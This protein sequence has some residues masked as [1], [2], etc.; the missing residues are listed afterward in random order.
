VLDNGVVYETQISVTPVAGGAD[1]SV[2]LTDGLNNVTPFA[3]QFVAGLVPYDGRVFLGARTGGAF[4]EHDVDNVAM[5]FDPLG[6]AGPTNIL[7]SDFEGL[8][9][10]LT[11]AG[12]TP[13]TEAELASPPGPELRQ[14]GVLPSEG[15]MRLT[16]DSA[17]QGNHIAFDR[18][19]P[20]AGGKVIA[21][22]DF[23]ILDADG[24]QGNFDLADGLSF[25]LADATQYGDTGALPSFLGEEPNLLAAFG[26]GIDTFNNNEEIGFGGNR[27]NHISLH[28]DGAFESLSIVDP[29][30]LDLAAGVFHHM[31]VIVE[32]TV[33]GSNVTV[34]VTDGVDGSSVTPFADFFIAGMSL[35][36]VRAAFGARTGGAFAFHDIDNVL[37]QY[38]V[39]EPSL[40]FLAGL[41]AWVTAR[42]ARRR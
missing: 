7:L 25:L 28:W 34:V 8:V 29:T 41:A 40:A 18:T 13:F 35:D 6:A 36:A 14:E 27:A 24:P 12:G 3:S 1:V 23:R 20:G 17:S 33:G 16:Q 11:L 9:G 30:E 10:G 21:E 2:S 42:W 39:P 31:E 19:A 37:V 15:L 4:S 32:E 22:F 26:V 5:T 38:A